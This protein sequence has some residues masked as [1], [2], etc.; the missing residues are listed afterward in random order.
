MSN[1]EAF[2]DNKETNNHK[3]TVEISGKHSEERVCRE[4]KTQSIY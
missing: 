4:F 3:E 2:M 1:K